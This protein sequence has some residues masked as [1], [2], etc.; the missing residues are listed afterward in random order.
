MPEKPPT[1]PS[2]EENFAF[3]HDIHKEEFELAWTPAMRKRIHQLFE[4]V[5]WDGAHK[6]EFRMKRLYEAYRLAIQDS[7]TN[8]SKIAARV[9]RNERKAK[10][11]WEEFFKTQMDLAAIAVTHG[12]APSIQGAKPP[13]IGPI[14]LRMKEI[15]GGKA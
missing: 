14:L 12:N 5:D 8:V 9:G 6:D 4:E 3:S 2:P 10:D 15:L 7:A 11:W 1:T 13:E